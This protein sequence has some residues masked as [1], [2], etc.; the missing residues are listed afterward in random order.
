VTVSPVGSGAQQPVVVRRMR[1]EEFSRVREVCVDAFGDP[2]LGE[3]LDALRSS[4]AWEDDLSFVAELDGQ[5]VGQVLY[6]HAFLDA[7]ER[8][9]DVLVLSPVGVRP[10]LHR[11]GIGSRLIT[12]SLRVLSARA[13]PLVFLE[14]HPTFYPRFGFRPGRELGFTA[15]SVRVPD[16][17]FMVR[18]L[19]SYE[20]WMTGALVYP[21]AFW[22]MDA[23][24]L[25]PTP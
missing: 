25:R 12:E 17:A 4:W 8:L 23:V 7:P 18:L 1:V 11:R 22:R 9:A 20:T 14:G 24:G 6:V 10:D 19:P 5:I 15:P 16:E 3:L 21:D 13:E 2:A